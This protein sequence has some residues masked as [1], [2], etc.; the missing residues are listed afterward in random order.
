M[1]QKKKHTSDFLYIGRFQK[2]KG[3]LYLAKLFQNQLRDYKLTV[4]GTKKEMIN[5]IFLFKK[6]KLLK[7]NFGNKKNY[8]D[9]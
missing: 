6:Y 7:S 3:S 9:L 4:V 5:K 8:K 2:D 1:T